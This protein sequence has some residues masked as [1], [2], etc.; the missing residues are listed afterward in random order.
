MGILGIFTNGNTLAEDPLG[1]GVGTGI[2]AMYLI[3]R[4]YRHATTVEK[5]NN[6]LTLC[7]IP[8]KAGMTLSLVIARS[9]SD[10]AIFISKH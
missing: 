6:T 1:E 10:E 4:R 5:Q 8:A 9:S 3:I 7:I 2:F